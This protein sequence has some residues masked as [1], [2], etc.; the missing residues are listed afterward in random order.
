MIKPALLRVRRKLVSE[1]DKRIERLDRV[2]DLILLLIS[3]ISAALL[4]FISSVPYSEEQVAGFERLLMISLRMFVIPV[5]LTIILWI[6]TQ[7]AKRQTPRVL[8]LK[9][10][11]WTYL[12]SMLGVFLFWVLTLGF[13]N[14]PWLILYMAG[15]ALLISTAVGGMLLSFVT[16]EYEK[17]MNWK[18]FKT[19]RWQLYRLLPIVS[20]VVLVEISIF[21]AYI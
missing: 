8:L 12:L 17:A 1:A 20:A 3:I 6:P 10:C 4:Q 13:A 16:V 15:L 19:K 21:V 11:A 7:L 2:F 18:L 9:M 14:V 5:I